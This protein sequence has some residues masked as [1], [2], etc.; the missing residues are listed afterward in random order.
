MASLDVNINKEVAE[1]APSTEKM[2]TFLEHVYL[3]QTQRDTKRQLIFI[4]LFI[5]GIPRVDITKQL[6]ISL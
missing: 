3:K 4:Y 2:V 1:T 5:C 6:R